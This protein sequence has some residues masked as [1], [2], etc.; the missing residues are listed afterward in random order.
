VHG[1]HGLTPDHFNDAAPLHLHWQGGTVK[2]AATDGCIARSVL[3]ATLRGH[4]ITGACATRC[5]MLLQMGCCAHQELSGQNSSEQQP[6]LGKHLGKV[7]SS[8]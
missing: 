4:L 3:Q 8:S 5:G 2:V 1:S 6:Q 7:I